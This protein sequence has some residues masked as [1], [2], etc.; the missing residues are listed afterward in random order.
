MKQ[1][2][3]AALLLAA[4]T[5][6]HAADRFT[7]PGGNS[8]ADAI[9]WL[10][11]RTACV[12]QYSGAETGDFTS[13]DPADL[14][15]PS[16]IRE[17]L[18]KESGNTTKTDMVYGICFD[19]AKAAY[20][21]ITRNQRYYTSLGVKE[22]YIAAA[23][24]DPRQIVLFQPVSSRNE[25]TRPPLNGVYVKEITQQNVRTHN[26][27]TVHGWLWVYTNDGTIYWID[28]TWT[29]NAG[30]VVWGVVRNG[31]EEQ[32]A[33]AARLCAVGI[34]GIAFAPFSRGDAA[35]NQGN[36]DQAIIDYNEAIQLEPINPATYNNRGDAYYKK[37][38]YKRAITDYTEA[39]KL[40]PNY[41]DAYAGR[42]AAYL[43]KGDLNR[44]IA[45]CDQAIKLDPELVPAYST[46][47]SAYLAKGD[48]NQALSDFNQALSLDPNY[49]RALYG[50]AQVH[51][52]QKNYDQAMADGGKAINLWP[53]EPAFYVT[54]AEAYHHKGDF[55]KAVPG[56]E[57]ALKIVPPPGSI[58]VDKARVNE[59][60]SLAKRR[61]KP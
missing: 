18:V 41:A 27:A 57:L 39:I 54:V 9:Q 61:R 16:H 34:P 37:G 26:D 11:V 30:Y 59:L 1:L 51:I 17:Y 40:D 53:K 35:R 2:I 50:R 13:P 6:V 60:I 36:Y 29:D 25:A 5:S 33:P 24:N 42:A 55:K 12:S 8:L 49:V 22:W 47:G 46:R 15:R 4:L 21:F 7:Q 58:G 23:F 19:F 38:D 10:A 20:E 31:R 45:D 48:M 32:V 43:A 52:A 28:P 3:S 14:Y 56:Y 44:A